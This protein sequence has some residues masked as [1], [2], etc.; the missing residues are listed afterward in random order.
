[1]HRRPECLLILGRFDVLVP[2]D[3]FFGRLLRTVFGVTWFILLHRWFRMIIVAFGVDQ[4]IE[5]SGAL[6]AIFT[7]AGLGAASAPSLWFLLGGF[8]FRIVTV[9]LLRRVHHVY[10]VRRGGY[11]PPYE[12]WFLSFS[13]IVV[14]TVDVSGV[15]V[16]HVS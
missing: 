4:S 10:I 11:P 9:L 6:V 15:E 5:P 12:Q 14:R 13:C 8:I 16:K 3:H 2:L 1:M 7:I